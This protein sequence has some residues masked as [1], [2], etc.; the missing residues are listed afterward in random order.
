MENSLLIGLSKQVALRRELDTVA[1]NIANVNTA[2]FKAD[3]SVFEEYMMPVARQDDFR[4]ADRRLRYVHDRASWLDLSQGPVQQTN[5]PLDVAVDGNGFIALQTPRGER[6]TRNGAFQIN[7]A[8]ELVTTEGFKVLGDNGPII[9]QTT[10]KDIAIAKDGTISVPNPG[11]GSDVR[12]KLR[13][14]E[15]AQPQ[16]LQKDSGSTFVP[17]EGQLAQASPTSRVNQGVIE[18]SNVRSV[19][20]MTRMIDIT[21]TYTM[22]AGL[23]QAHGDLRRT[24]VERLADVPA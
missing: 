23:M 2:G 11:G 16:R 6:Y 20:E 5:N 10:D 7:A 12:G 21:R 15:F 22:I 9:F 3:S 18:K 13:V 14:V 17:P 4:G 8:G 1:N 19:V 24:A